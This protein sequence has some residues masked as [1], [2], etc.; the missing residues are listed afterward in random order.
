MSD[1]QRGFLIGAGVLVAVLVVGTV[2]GIFR[3]V[4]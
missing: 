2:A 4:V 1:F 3:Q